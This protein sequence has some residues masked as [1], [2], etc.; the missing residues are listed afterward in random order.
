MSKSEKIDSSFWTDQFQ[1]MYENRVKNDR[2]KIEIPV[3]KEIQ[4]GKIQNNIY[5]LNFLALFSAGFPCSQDKREGISKHFLSFFIFTL[6]LY[7]P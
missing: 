4:S 6:F 3:N 5:I 1:G 7:I 2:K